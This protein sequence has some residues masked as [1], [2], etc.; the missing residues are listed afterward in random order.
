MVLRRCLVFVAAVSLLAVALV[1]V[2]CKGKD[3]EKQAAPPPRASPTLQVAP[4]AAQRAAGVAELARL[5]GEGAGDLAL[6]V[7]ATRSLG[8]IGD[9]PAVAALLKLLEDGYPQVRAAAIEGLALAGAESA[10]PAV[11]G[12]LARQKKTVHRIGVARALGRLGGPGQE[13]TMA[14]LLRSS[15]PTITAATATALGVWG[16]RGVPLPD[17]VRRALLGLAS[18]SDPAVRYGVAYALAREHE[19]VANPAASAALLALLDD[20]EAETRAVAATGLALRKIAAT[21]ALVKRLRTDDDWRVQVQAV[22]A[23]AGETEGAAGRALLASWVE[24]TWNA[25]SADKGALSSARI[26]PLVEALTVLRGHADEKAVAGMFET[27]EALARGDGKRRGWANTPADVGGRDRIHCLAAAGL[28]QGG[29]SIGRVPACG[30]ASGAGWPVAL[31]KLLAV[32]VAATRPGDE[33]A[34]ELFLGMAKDDDPRVRAAA[35]A[36]MVSAEGDVLDA[37]VAGLIPAAASD[38]GPVVAGPLAAAVAQRARAGRSVPAEWLEA[39]VARA[40]AETRDPELRTTI[41]DALAAA[42]VEDARALCQWALGDTNRSVR[43]RAARCLAELEGEDPGKAKLPAAPAAAPTFELAPLESVV[44]KQVVWTVKTGRGAFTIEL[45]PATAPYSVAALTRLAQSGFYDGLSWHR[46]VRD[47][48]AQGGDPTGSGWGGPGWLLP[49]EHS[50]E[51][52]D[53]GAVG[54]ADAG[55]D[56]GGCQL[57]V[58][59]SRAAHLEGR[60]TRVGRVTSGM[61]VVDSLLAGDTIESV[62]ASVTEPAAGVPR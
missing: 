43:E 56:T 23:L 6:R 34:R 47:F 30:E 3:K 58:M 22:R 50:F 39:I 13:S 36:A 57:F 46:I 25:L 32:E 40:R 53:R 45:D 4:L 14:L 41:V 37:E 21:D 59:H 29:Y 20:S 26:Q 7:D 52:Y 44:D 16:R 24:D 1:A 35:I 11:A 62:T 27:V 12:T 5:A 51:L 38:D 17:A 31:R 55:L 8:R 48:V 54:I 19:P 2:G 18:A 15:D 49:A 61:E 28:V 60:Y 9:E 42:K 10:A 33:G